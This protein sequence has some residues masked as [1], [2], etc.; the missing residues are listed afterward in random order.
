MNNIEK[1]LACSIFLLLTL[2]HSFNHKK[3]LRFIYKTE[4]L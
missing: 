3:Q 1:K 4:T 2:M